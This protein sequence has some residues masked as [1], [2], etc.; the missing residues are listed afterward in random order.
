MIQ[1]IQKEAREAV[2][3]MQQGS[4]EVELGVTNTEGSGRA[5]DKIIEMASRVGDMVVQI[6]TAATQQ[7]ATAELVDANIGN[8]AQMTTQA[9]VNAA[10]TAKSSI[11]LSNLAFN[12]QTVVGNFKLRARA[13]AAGS[14]ALPDRALPGAS[15]HANHAPARSRTPISANPSHPYPSSSATP[16]RDSHSSLGL[17]Q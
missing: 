11:D 16:K 1:S 8:I 17:L 2:S 4:Q 3:A 15:L 6:A 7:S 9:S 14:N 10:A 13:P 12:M 5:L